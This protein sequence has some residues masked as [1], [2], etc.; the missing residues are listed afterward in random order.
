[1]SRKYTYIYIYIYIYILIYTIQTRKM[2]FGKGRKEVRAVSP[3]VSVAAVRPAL[4]NM[5][6]R[7]DKVESG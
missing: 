3:D 6:G 5:G 1:M 7:M 4:S 2:I